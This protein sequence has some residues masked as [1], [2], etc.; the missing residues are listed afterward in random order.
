MPQ[1]NWSLQKYSDMCKDKTC[2]GAASQESLSAATAF[3]LLPFLAA[4]QPQANNGPFQKT[5]AT[6][7]DWLV[8][9]QKADGDLSADAESQMYSHGMATIVLCEDYGV[10]QD[11]SRRRAAQKA[12][13][14][15]EAAQNTKTGGWR[16]HPGED[17]DTSVFGWQLTALKS[18]QMA[19]LIGEAGNGRRREEMARNRA[20]PA[21][22]KSGNSLISQKCNRLRRCRRSA[23]LSNQY[24]HA[25]QDRSCQSSAASSS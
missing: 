14:F 19:G 25:G 3:G 2:T 1:G 8:S 4:G 23:S 12:I 5:V 10:T 24:F 13:D 7:I 20:P 11:K 22:T 18:A 15:I 9:H 16:Y 17:G 21:E 6:G